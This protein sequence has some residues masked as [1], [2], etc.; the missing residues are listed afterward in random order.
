MS[1]DSRNEFVDLEPYLIPATKKLLIEI[2]SKNG[3]KVHLRKVYD[4]LE[5]WQINIY[6]PYVID[7]PHW[8]E[9]NK[10]LFTHELLHIYFDFVLDMKI[11]HL[12]LQFLFRNLCNNGEEE[13]FFE[14]EYLNQVNI[15]IKD[16]FEKL[17]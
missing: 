13:H 1:E 2:E 3:F 6:T 9:G 5:T 8:D 16:C 4:L 14:T 17:I 15:Y 10:V 12:T 7:M 11:Y